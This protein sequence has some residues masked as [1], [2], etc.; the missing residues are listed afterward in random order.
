MLLVPAAAAA[1]GTS[2]YAA[3]TGANGADAISQYD[4]GSDGVL[5]QKVPPTVAGGNA[6]AGIVLSPDGKSV[7]VTNNGAIGAGGVSQYEVGSGGALSPMATP[8]VAAGRNPVGIAVS[9]DGTSAYVANDGANGAGAVSQYDVGAGAVLS[10]KTTPTVSG[11][12]QPYGIAVSPDGKSAYVTNLNSN[13]AGGISQYDVGPGGAL[14]PKAIATVAAG[15]GPSGVAV[16]P[17][18]K[19]VYV[20]NLNSNGAGGI[21]QYDVG[22]GGVLTPKATP[23]VAS[24]DSPLAIAVSP[25]GRSVYVV[26]SGA[27]GADGV[28]QYD[29]GPGGELTPQAT[30][31]VAAG[32]GPSGV[33]VSPEGKS[34]YVTNSNANGTDG[35][36]EY[37]VGAGGGLTPKTPPTVAAGNEPFAVAVTP[38]QAPVAAFTPTPALPGL[39]TAFDGSASS[40]S[41]GQTVAR[42]DWSFG[43]GTGATNAGP[44]PV[45]V[46]A[47]PG[48]YAVT[49]TVTDNAGCSTTIV[50]T[51]QTVSC[52][53]GPTA[54]KTLEITVALPPPVPITRPQ[55]PRVRITAPANG[56]RY[57]LGQAVHSSFACTEGAA[58]TGLASCRDQRGQS[59]GTE[60]DTSTAGPHT[61]TASA[62][63]RDGLIASETV[64]Y[65]VLAPARVL[66]SDMDPSP[67]RH[68]CVVETDERA[69]ELIAISADATCRHLRLRLHG[70]IRTR[71][72]HASSAGGTITVTYKVK[73]PYGP[74][75]GSVR[76]RVNHS[77]WR[78]SIVLPGVNLDP[79]P[80]IYLIAI[81]YSGDRDLQP[82]TIT[83]RIRLESERAPKV[84]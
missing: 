37:D 79:L 82:A 74:A 9:P 80:P 63:S 44:S 81:H 24:G 30:P 42:Y 7:Y 8:T 49:L 62:R 19:S 48:E 29:V 35:I 83:R 12:N 51:G 66:I 41:P 69:R 40:A 58:G 55:P 25:D 43:D 71:V 64:T 59:S 57:K 70:T 27:N 46:Y 13:G 68:G 6:P 34:V 54:I 17:D 32:N 15:N 26:N 84:E 36:S 18:G 56:A 52:N 28:S 22:P 38:D 31:T 39:A 50:F 14:T 5:T 77:R 78:I 33:A 21:S 72:G 73:L 23:T 45:H 10:P 2:A 47:S 1:A 11:G 67:L 76:A 3:N 75:T 53:G 60:I 65:T 4:I 61:F 16:S 20:T